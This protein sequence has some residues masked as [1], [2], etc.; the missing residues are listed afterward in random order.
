MSKT[1]VYIDETGKKGYLSLPG[2]LDEPLNM[3]IPEFRGMSDGK[4]FAVHQVLKWSTQQPDAQLRFEL[5]CNPEEVGIELHG[6]LTVSGDDVVLSATIRNA[7]KTPIQSGHHS[8]HLDMSTS[9]RFADTTGERTYLYAE[10]GW[11]TM[12]QLLDPVQSRK[13]TIRMGASYKKTT[14]MWKMMARVRETKDLM[15]ALALD[16]GYAFGSDHPDWP[17]GILG[18]YRWGTIHPSES[19]N[20]VGKIYLIKG[21]VDDLRLRYSSDFK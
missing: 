15:V 14:V 12:A 1:R 21:G 3:T 6:A 10:T 2:I 13:H 20:L 19:K 5:D 17:I 16:K 8:L 4:P 9:S 18:G 7:T 11:A